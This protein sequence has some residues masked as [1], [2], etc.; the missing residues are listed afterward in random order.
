MNAKYQ[1][2]RKDFKTPHVVV[3]VNRI[4]QCGKNILSDDRCVIKEVALEPDEHTLLKTNQ[5]RDPHLAEDEAHTRQIL[6]EAEAQAEEKA[7]EKAQER[8][9]KRA[10]LSLSLVRFIG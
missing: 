2:S 10:R 9:H 7:E 8:A 1:C 4:P 5:T 3:F 6:D